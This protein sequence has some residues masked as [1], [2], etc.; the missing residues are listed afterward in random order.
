MS[1]E[2][3]CFS[4]SQEREAERRQA[5]GCS[6]TRRRA[7]DVGPQALARRL[8]FQRER[9]PLGAPPRRLLAPDP[10]WRNLRA[11]HMSGALGLALAHSRVP[12][13]VAEG[14]FC[15]APPG[16]RLR[17]ARAGRR[18]PLRLWLVSGD[19]LSE[20]DGATVPEKSTPSSRTFAQMLIAGDSGAC[21]SRVVPR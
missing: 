9:S 1:S 15:R 2:V 8:A 4:L 20:R 12:L 6:G 16:A 5:L 18:I 21:L 3:C 11:L 14:R 19:A 13:V 17:A 7:S 10:P